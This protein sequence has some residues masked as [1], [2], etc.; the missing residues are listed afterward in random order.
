MNFLVSKI[1][2]HDV[3]HFFVYGKCSKDEELNVQIFS[4][5][6]RIH[7]DVNQYFLTGIHNGLVTKCIYIHSELNSIRDKGVIMSSV[8][9]QKV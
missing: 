9:R 4:T 2:V 3:R 1:H 5:H 7:P 6:S 8:Y